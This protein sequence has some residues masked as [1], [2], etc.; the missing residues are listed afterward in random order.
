M[1]WISKYIII[2]LLLIGFIPCSQAQQ[3]LIGGQNWPQEEAAYRGNYFLTDMATETA[4]HVLLFQ[5][6]DGGW[7]KGIYYPT[8]ISENELATISE[9]KKQMASS[10]YGKATLTEI[11]FLSNMYQAT[12]RRKYKKA[13]EEGIGYLVRSQYSN[14]GW[15]LTASNEK[16]IFSF[17]DNSFIDIMNLLWR[18]AEGK[19]PYDFVQAD[20]RKQCREAFE[21]GVGLI[22]NTQYIQN[23]QPSIWCTYYDAETLLPVAGSEQGILA[24]NS[25][26][27]DNLAGLLMGLKGPSH[28]ITQSIEGAKN[29]YEQHKISGLTRQNYINKQGKR[30]FRF[31]EDKHA[32]DMWALFYH[33]QSNTP[34][35]YEQDGE[36]KESLDDL[37]YEGRKSQSWFNNDGGKLLRT[38][39]KWKELQ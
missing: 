31:V 20:I 36:I 35:F 25:Q 7:P 8:H 11:H 34:L 38:Y 30:D 24:L 1:S 21:K 4:D 33:P 28:E 10:V 3:Y 16:Q 39:A 12:S 22:I 32:P 9:A 27:S 2:C 6:P 23:G 37:S 19:Q 26:I 5:M 13:A 18:I 14:G 29:W 15:P 17:A